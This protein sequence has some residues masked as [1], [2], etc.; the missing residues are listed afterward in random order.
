MADAQTNC[1]IQARVVVKDDVTGMTMPA[2]YLELV[3]ENRRFLTDDR[4]VAVVDTACTPP[5]RVRVMALGFEPQ[6]LTL[7]SGRE[8]V[9]RMKA[10]SKSL[11]QTEVV[12]A[13][14]EARS[15]QAKDTVSAIDMERAMG[16]N[17]AEHL[18]SVSGVTVLQTGSSV[19]KPVIHGLHSQRLIIMNA[20]IRQE[21]QQWGTEHAPEI[22]PFIAN[23][24]Q[25]IKGASSIRYGADAIGGVILVE[26]RE[27]PHEPGLQAE[28]NLVGMSNGR[29]GVASGIV[30]QHLGKFFDLCWRLQG[31]ARKSGTVQTPDVYLQNTAFD[32]V[33]WSGS[34]G[35]ERKKWGTEVFYS[36]FSTRLG[37]FSGS[38]IGNLSDLR[39][40]IASG[41][42][43]TDDRFSYGIDK[44]RQ[45][46]THQLLSW[47]A[48]LLIGGVGTL[49]AQYGYQYN[50]R[51]E[52][53]RDRPYNDS[54]AALD[55][56]ELELRLYTQTADLTLETRK[57][58][59]FTMVTGLS[60]MIQDNQYG[61]MRFFV[62]NYVLYNGSAYGIIRWRKNKWE[63]E[64]GLRYDYRDQTV[65]RIVNGE[66]VSTNYRF[67]IPNYA[68]GLLYKADSSTTLRF[69]TGTAQRAPS[70]NEWFSNG[71]HHGT[72]SFE[73]G[74]PGLGA[75]KAWSV[76]AGLQYR[77]RRLA[78]DATLYTMF[79][80]DYIYLV[81]A[82]KEVLTISGAYPSFVYRNVDALFHG[83]D[84]TID[85]D[86]H[87]K[88]N[89]KSRNS[90]VLAENRTS[91]RFLEF[92]P[93]PRFEQIISYVA[94]AK[95]LWTDL[96]A[97]VSVIHVMRQW[98]YEPGSDYIPPPSAYTLLG[99]EV[100]G[101]YTWKGQQIRMGLSVNNLLNTTYRDYMNRLRYY[102]DEA[103]TNVILRITIPMY[104]KTAE[105]N[106]AH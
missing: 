41:E 35:L 37:I 101:I 80:R 45:E 88:W 14:V 74:D 51:L 24:I 23:R 62:P 66:V 69:N 27:L 84:L 11:R 59:G 15:T 21:G 95:G 42:T 61:G 70:I 102:S 78:L 91:R 12:A 71:L 87:R 54:L 25:V 2:V 39:R 96:T 5:Y 30:E 31:T 3:N 106:H 100:S 8:L 33:N 34:L 79:I 64:G 86:F 58:G 43:R 55:L 16:K 40:V 1:L 22:D 75:E 77:K 81:P 92:V 94:G 63:A 50:R 47:K 98:R 18:R 7:R 56:P 93:A 105:H 104:F 13:R 52:F 29:A 89:L 26:P 9:V 97:G 4:G 46:V 60:G 72:A 90:V 83:A 19:M 6:E 53:D 85:W 17:L 65:Y 10:S 73:T 36:R 103:G 67:R 32:E 76:S 48:Y 49:R 44:P 38:H 20:G 82:A 28:V 68:A 99:L 57:V